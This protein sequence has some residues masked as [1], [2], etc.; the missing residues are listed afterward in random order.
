MVLVD[1][2]RV[3]P[4]FGGEFELVHEVVVHVMRAPRVEQRGMDVDPHRG[5]LL[6][7][8]VGQF[9]IRHQVK[10]HQLHGSLLRSSAT[11]TLRQGGDCHAQTRPADS[12]RREPRGSSPHRGSVGRRE[13]TN[14]SL[15]LAG[16]LSVLDPVV[17]PFRHDAQ[18]TPISSSTRSTASIRAGRLSLRWSRDIE[19]E[20]DGLSLDVPTLRDGLRFHDKSRC[21]R[22]MSS[23][24]SAALP[25]ASALPTL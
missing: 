24:A 22:T 6:A 1:A 14:W 23:P 8:I 9:G 21:W 2:D 17:T 5:M 11:S 4:A 3:E 19:F 7:E 12:R 15:L 20:E 13:P 10:P 25:R 16:D 18:F